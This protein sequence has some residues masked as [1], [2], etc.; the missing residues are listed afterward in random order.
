M[1]RSLPGRV[2]AALIALT[3]LVAAPRALEA[4]ARLTASTPATGATLDTSPKTIRLTFSEAPTLAFSGMELAGPGGAVALGPL[5]IDSA[6]KL[7]LVASV[8]ATLAPGTYTVTWHAAAADGHPSRGM[9][10]FVVSARAAMPAPAAA[11][12]APPPD[13]SHMAMPAAG[14]ASKPLAVES[15][16]YTVIRFT[17]YASL[18]MLIGA[19]LFVL[20]LVRRIRALGLG[21]DQFAEDAAGAARK[22]GMIAAAVLVLATPARL[23]AQSLVVQASMT[24]VLGE[25]WGRAWMLQL[26]GA[27]IALAAV[28]SARGVAVMKW[29]IVGLGA[30]AIAL[31]FALSGHAVAAPRYASLQVAVDTVHVVAAGAWIGTLF[32]LAF[33]GIPASLRAVEGTRGPLAAALVNAFSPMALFAAG[34][35]VLTGTYQAWQNIG[36]F[37]ALFHSFYGISLLGKLTAVALVMII[38]AKN[39]R[40]LKPKLGTEEAARDIRKSAMWELGFALVVIAMTAGLVAMPTPVDMARQAPAASQSTDK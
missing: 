27:L 26:F 32:A 37:G 36:S 39:W 13:T 25:L 8:N 2:A 9:F 30:I 40:M 31:G 3:L 33:A 18:L 38:G 24:A 20:L 17:L 14:A 15:P 29:R 23:L 10:K 34:V 21:S 4:H 6:S 11:P 22:L 5:A 7:T 16:V 1:T 35:L 19:T 12:P 28:L